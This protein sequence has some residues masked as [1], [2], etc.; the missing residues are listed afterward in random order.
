METRSLS[1][2]LFLLFYALKYNPLGPSLKS[3][4]SFI[5]GVP[6]TRV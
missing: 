6:H 2:R 5:T 3:T 4:D 1:L